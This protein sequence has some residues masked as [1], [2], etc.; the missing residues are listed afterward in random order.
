MTIVHDLQE[1]LE[2]RP[3]GSS[4]PL[5]RYDYGTRPKPFVHPLRTPAGWC[6]TNFEPHDHLWHRGLWYAIK[7]VNGHNFWEERAPFGTQELLRGVEVFTGID[8][9]VLVHQELGWFPQGSDVPL[10]HERRSLHFVPLDH[11]SYRLD[12]WTTLQAWEDLLLDR[13]EFT[14]WGG[15]GGLCLRGSRNWYDTTILLADGATT[16]RPTGQRAAWASLQGKIDG[17]DRSYAG[18]AVF[19]HPENPRHPVPWYG[20]T[21]SGHYLNAAFLFHEPMALAAGEELASLYSLHVHDDLW[22]RDRIQAAYEAWVAQ[23][24]VIEATADKPWQDEA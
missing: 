10:I 2:L 16:D 17:G 18:V 22:D 6:L 4:Q 14:T 15:Y 13:T 9:D 19:D 7:F 20:S 5:W 12:W 1:A 21:G 8:G 23:L 3:G 24:D 11:E